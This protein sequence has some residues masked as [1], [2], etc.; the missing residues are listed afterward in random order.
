MVQYMV[1]WCAGVG[2]LKISVDVIATNARALHVFAKLGFECEGRKKRQLFIR[3]RY[4]DE[5]MLS[6]FIEGEGEQNVKTG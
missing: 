4:E 1:D 3:G 2:Y 5:E 6:I